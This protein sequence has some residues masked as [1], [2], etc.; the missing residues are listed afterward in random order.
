MCSILF[1]KIE[2]REQAWW[3]VTSKFINYDML[4]VH[5]RVIYFA[6]SLFCQIFARDRSETFTRDSNSMTRSYVVRVRSVDLLVKLPCFTNNF[7][8]YERTSNTYFNHNYVH[9]SKKNIFYFNYPRQFYSRLR[10]LSY[11][12][13]RLDH[14]P[15]NI[16]KFA[17]QTKH[18]PKEACS[19]LGDSIIASEETT[20]MK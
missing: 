12:S 2:R 20:T 19:A 5:R 6:A 3:Y 18:R 16:L 7:D 15:L 1:Y 17:L 4:H 8:S 9:N 13:T 11:R 10:H 14:S